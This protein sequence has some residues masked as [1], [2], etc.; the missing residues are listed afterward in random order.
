MRSSAVAATADAAPRART[1][2]KKHGMMMIG[3]SAAG[4]LIALVAVIMMLSRGNEATPSGSGAPSGAAG[5]TAAGDAGGAA[6][7]TA[8]IPTELEVTSEPRGASI[9]LNGVD[10]KQQTP[11]KISVAGQS[12]PVRVVLSRQGYKAVEAEITAEDLRAGRKEFKL[13]S[14][15]RSTRLV[16]SGPF[17]FELVQG[18]QVISRAAMSHELNVQSGAPIVARSREKFVSQ[19]LNV[20]FNRSQGTTIALQPLGLL[21]VFGSPACTAVVDGVDVGQ[22]PI[23]DLQVGSGQHTVVLKCEGRPDQTQRTQAASGAKQTVTS[24]AGTEPSNETCVAGADRRLGRSRDRLPP[25][26]GLA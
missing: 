14:D 19:T 12:L 13:A 4:V 8:A 9:L 16:V 22:P 10:T 15:V 24:A 25:R 23:P 3:A 18:S 20:D 6:S 5:R 7:G 17:E 26:A 1:E 2:D 11:V 21:A